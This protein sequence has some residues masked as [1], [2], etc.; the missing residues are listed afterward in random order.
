MIL[1]VET[2]CRYVGSAAQTLSAR[3]AQHRYRLRKGNHDNPKLQNSWNKHG[4][5][6]FQFIPLCNC[7]PAHALDLESEW[8]NKFKKLGLPLYNL[9]IDVKSQLGMVPSEETRKKIAA[10]HTGKKKIYTPQGI[11][12]IIKAMLGNQ[13]GKAN[14]KPF[15]VIS[16]T[17]ERIEGSNLLEWCASRGLD[18]SAMAKVSSGKR[19]SHKGYTAPDARAQYLKDNPL[20]RP[21]NLTKICEVCGKE[22]HIMPSQ[23]ARQFCTNACRHVHDKAAYAGDK[24]PNYRHGGRVAGVKRDRHVSR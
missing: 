4:E 19:P 22:F 6:A 21:A 23:S 12:S 8:F 13:S 2:N 15:T 18:F 1:N 7:A 9:R 14:A 24:N 11:A 20:K 17:G 5:A 10:A 16:P 3:F